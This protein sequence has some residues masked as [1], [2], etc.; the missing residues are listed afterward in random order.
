MNQSKLNLFE[1]C[2]RKIIRVYLKSFATAITKK[3]FQLFSV[4]NLVLKINSLMYMLVI[5]IM[6]KTENLHKT[7]KHIHLIIV[8]ILSH[9]R[10]KEGN[11]VKHKHTLS[12]SQLNVMCRYA[13]MF[14]RNIRY[15]SRIQNVSK[16]YINKFIICK[17]HRLYKSDHAKQSNVG[18]SLKDKKIFVYFKPHFNLGF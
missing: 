6:I 4:I 18:L 10:I 5:N 12:D 13:K 9:I 14:L 11:T 15:L 3:K 17:M 1:K 8:L 7:M 2:W 16:H